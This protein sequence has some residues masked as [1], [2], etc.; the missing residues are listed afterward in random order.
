[1]VGG[2]L[3]PEARRLLDL[4]Q[5][6]RIAYLEKD[7]W[8]NYP[9]AEQIL[10][11]LKELFLLPRTHRMPNMLIIGPTNNGKTMIKEK[12]CKAYND[13]AVYKDVGN[14]YGKELLE[15]SVISV[16]MPAIPS[17]RTLLLA[18]CEEV[19]QGERLGYLLVSLLTVTVYRILKSLNVKMV[20]IDELHNMLASTPRQRLEFFNFIRHLGNELQIPLVCLGTKDAYLAIRTDPQLEN[21]FEPHVLPLWQEGRE[22]S[23]LLE[24]FVA[25]LPLYEYS[26]LTDPKIVNWLLAQSGGILG[27]IV[28]ILKQAAKQAI[29]SGK[30]RIDFELLQQLNYRSPSERIKIFEKE[31]SR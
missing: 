2:H 10:A 11:R 15:K 13:A 19:G 31:L 24:S 18:M 12:F 14:G 7:L 3:R 22:L 26:A 27:E 8:I 23:N 17:V 1:M 28:V 4:L 30:E 25:T 9:R 29:R 6:D 16:Q 21:R 5:P 20:I